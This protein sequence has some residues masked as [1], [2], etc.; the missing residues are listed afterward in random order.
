M[1]LKKAGI[2]DGNSINCI[3]EAG[4]LLGVPCEH[5]NMHL[6]RIFWPNTKPD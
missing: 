3:T 4:Y 2:E 6:L 1:F 5:G